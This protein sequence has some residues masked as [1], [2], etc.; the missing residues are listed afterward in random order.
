MKQNHYAITAAKRKAAANT[1]R[2][3]E[4]ERDVFRACVHECNK[5]ANIKRYKSHCNQWAI[6]HIHDYKGRMLPNKVI[7]IVSC[8]NGYVLVS[9]L[10]ANGNIVNATKYPN[11]T[12]IDNRL[13]CEALCLSP[14]EYHKARI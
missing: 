14:N 7:A 13:I 2:L 5:R 8:I 1:K 10:D 3:R 11:N 9:N 6:Y 4:F 12:R